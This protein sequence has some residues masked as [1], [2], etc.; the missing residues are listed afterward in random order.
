MHL[1]RVFL[2]LVLFSYDFAFGQ[3]DSLINSGIQLEKAKILTDSGLHDLAIKELKR[4]EPRDTNYLK[5]LSSLADVHLSNQ[6]YSDAIETAQMGLLYPSSF[7]SNFL[8]AQGMAYTQ[9]GDYEK[10]TTVFDEGIKEFPFYP[11]FTVQKG[12]MYYTQGEYDEAEKLFLEALQLSPFNS[13]SHLHLGIISILRG[14][15]VRGMMAMGIYLAI[16]NTDNKQLVLLERFVKNEV[17]DEFSLPPSSDNAFTRLD[18]ILRSQIAMEDGY[19]SRIPIDAGVVKQYQLLFDQLKLK[20]YNASDPWI[21]YYLPVYRQLI[22]SNLQDAFVYHLLKSTSIKKVPEWTK[23]N[24]ATLDQF[25]TEVNSALRLLRETKMLPGLGYKETVSCWYDEDS[26]LESIGNKNANNQPIGLWHYFFYNGVMQ[27]RGDYDTKGKKTGIW[28]YYNDSGYL[29]DVENLDTGLRERFT[30]EGK[31]WQKYY[32]RNSEVDGEVLIYYDCGVVHE[33]LNYRDGRRNGS[34]E[35]YSINGTLRERYTYLNDSLDGKYESFFETGEK[36]ATSYYEHGNLHGTITHFHR[37]GNVLS[38]GD[39]KDGKATGNWKF[40]HE[41]GQLSEEGQYTDDNPSGEFRYYDR[42]GRLTEVRNHNSEGKVHGE[43]T[44]YQNGTLYSRVKNENGRIVAAAYFDQAGK[45][46]ASYQEL[47]GK[48]NGRSHFPTGEVRSEY[49]YD[50]GKAS[51]KWKYYDRSGYLES[52]YEYV[53][54]EIHGQVVEYHPNKVVK[55][56][57]YYDHGKKHGLYQQYFTNGKM[58]TQGWYAQGLTQQRWL[59]YHPNGAIKSDEYFLNGQQAGKAYYYSQDGKL[60]TSDEMIDE[61]ILDYRINNEHGEQISSLE[62]NKNKV[63]VSARQKSGREFQHMEILCGKLNGKNSVLFFDGTQ[64]RSRNYINGKLHGL[65]ERY[66]A[67]GE[68]IEKGHYVEGESEGKWTWYNMNGAI[69]TIGSYL[70]D[71]PDSVWAYYYDNGTIARENIHENGKR[72]GI[73]K[74]YGPDGQLILE[75][76]YDQGDLIAFHVGGTP[77]DAWNMF[78]GTGTIKAHYSDGKPA[79]E[80][81]YENGLLHGTEKIYYK[82][83]KLF[84]HF[85]FVYGDYEGPQITYYPDGKVRTKRNYQ[86]DD[87]HGSWE[88]YDATGKLER[89]ERYEFGYLNGICTLYRN[90]KKVKEVKFWYGL[91]TE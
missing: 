3:V 9:Q 26:R 2:F 15:K 61:K 56:K 36:Q 78:S 51:G 33:Q 42:K 17:I 31:P 75:K 57:L 19:K 44:L 68:L 67:F 79:I 7:R 89:V 13:I 5:S 34:G 10:A 74:V 52:E 82:N 65:S 86:L 18:G 8:L 38:E 91:P 47:N 11:A 22:K 27:A 16:N 40:Y 55:V 72:Q 20:E 71:K 45:E 85:N 28:K 21:E 76:K 25:Y 77:E 43:N 70:H 87:G 90:G 41:N 59:S 80:E 62:N 58:H 84:S 48:L 60:F 73:S 12:K 63:V 24:Q 30:K 54:D 81:Q 1:Y 83:G 32:L 6:Q 14:E 88:W 50:N 39:Y 4:I 64:F 29:I 23:K 35:I 66:G 69:E 37:V 46:I 53:N 49:S